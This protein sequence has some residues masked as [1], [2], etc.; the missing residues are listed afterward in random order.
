[1]RIALIFGLL[2]LPLFS[3]AQEST[4]T[5]L[6][7]LSEGFQRN[8]NP[9]RS[10][11]LAT[12]NGFIFEPLFIVDGDKKHY[13]LAKSVTYS[14]D[15]RKLTITLRSGIRWSD[16]KPFTAE[17]VA[18]SLNLQATQ[19]ELD[20]YNIGRHIS[21]VKQ[22]GPLRVDVTLKQPDS[23]FLP[24][25]ADS[26]IVPYHL[27]K[28]ITRPADYLNPNPVGTGP[29]T[30]IKELTERHIKQCRNPYYWQADSL[31]VDCLITRK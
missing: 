13:R 31:K 29:F 10:N 15:L 9:F 14:D 19:P 18:Y 11:V 20:I 5:V 1:M 17:D 2:L 16:G 30:D 8:F 7:K 24:I 27:W 12:T 28:A 3:Q 4:L 25:L 21:S 26:P 6:P 23:Q 22:T